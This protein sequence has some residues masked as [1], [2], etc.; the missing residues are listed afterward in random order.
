MKIFTMI[1]VVLLLSVI[2]M[3]TMPIAHSE[4][5]NHSVRVIV[6][7]ECKA[8]IS[9]EIKRRES[10]NDIGTQYRMLPITY[11]LPSYP[12]VSQ[13]LELSNSAKSISELSRELS[14]I[15]SVCWS[16]KHSKEFLI[17]QNP[18]ATWGEIRDFMIQETITNEFDDFKFVF[19]KDK[20][21]IYMK[22]RHPSGFNG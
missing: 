22:P 12:R 9:S 5:S 16:L 18:E 19:T 17:D 10:L 20:I 21:I 11:T 14:S 7:D 2:V 8:V 4:E 15:I 6:R 3:K 1:N 13:V